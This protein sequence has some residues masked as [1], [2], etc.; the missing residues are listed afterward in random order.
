VTPLPLAGQHPRGMQP[1]RVVTDETFSVEWLC[2]ARRWLLRRLRYTPSKTPLVAPQTTLTGQRRASQT[3]FLAWFPA[4]GARQPDDGED[5]RV[6]GD[7]T[8]GRRT[9]PPGCT[10]GRTRVVTDH[11]VTHL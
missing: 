11:W 7:A 5:R 1:T 3:T 9:T 8:N 6:T 10:S 4:A 2:N